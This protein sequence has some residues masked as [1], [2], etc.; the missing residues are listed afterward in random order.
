MVVHDQRVASRS[1]E[2][3]ERLCLRAIVVVAVAALFEE[4]P[5]FEDTDQQ[6]EA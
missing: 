3:W 4:Q 2:R 6:A 1:G 5:R